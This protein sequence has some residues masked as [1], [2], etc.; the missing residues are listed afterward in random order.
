MK[1][2]GGCC[3]WVFVGVQYM[4]EAYFGTFVSFAIS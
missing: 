3:S 2:T 4:E 1:E